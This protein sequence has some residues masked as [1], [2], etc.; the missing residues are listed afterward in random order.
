MGLFFPT[1]LLTFL[2]LKRKKT[3][4]VIK[5][6]GRVAGEAEKDKV[7]KYKTL[8]VWGP[9]GYKFI[10]ELERMTCGK[11]MEKRPS[12]FISISISIKKL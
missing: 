6:A 4:K 2:F 5:K 1:F 8:G 9:A 11:T 7:N 12:S 10:K 3:S